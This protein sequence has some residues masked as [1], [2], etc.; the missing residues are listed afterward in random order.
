MENVNFE[1]EKMYLITMSV[2]RNLFNK[3]LVSKE[4]YSEID[5]IFQD[6]YSPSLGSLFTEIA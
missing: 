2:M 4:E 3:G 6:K 5:T 1:N